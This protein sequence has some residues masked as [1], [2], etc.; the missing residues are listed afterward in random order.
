MNVNT[1]AGEATFTID[2]P[3]A[4]DFNN[5]DS[6]NRQVDSFQIDIAPGTSAKTLQGDVSAIIRGDEIHIVHALR[7]RDASPPDLSDPQSGGWGKVRGVVP[8]SVNGAEVTFTLPLSLIGAPDGHFAYNA[9]ILRDGV[10]RAE[11]QAQSVP[12][13]T[14]LACGMAMLMLCLAIALG[15]AMIESRRMRSGRSF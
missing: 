3:S 11:T 13:P 12:L 2:F 9:L 8:I 14:A 10:T 15:K 5:V 6:N 4:P 7:M 1:A